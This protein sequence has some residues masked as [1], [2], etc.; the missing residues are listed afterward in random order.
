MGEPKP[1]YVPENYLDLNV[2]P[3]ADAPLSPKKC[4]ACY[5]YYDHGDV[6]EWE[7][8][9]FS[10]DIRW[11]YLMEEHLRERGLAL[12]YADYLAKILERTEAKVTRFDL[13]HATPLQRCQAAIWLHQ[14][15]TCATEKSDEGDGKR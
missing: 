15:K 9:P 6:P 10:N 11:A 5:C 8:Q 7:P 4:W 13:A 12:P 14:E 1:D 2:I 3:S